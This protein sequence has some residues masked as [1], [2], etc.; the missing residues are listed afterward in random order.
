M[1]REDIIVKSNDEVF[2][3]IIDTFDRTLAFLEDNPEFNSLDIF[4]L[5]KEDAG[6]SEF[7][8]GG[9]EEL[10]EVVDLCY[11]TPQKLNDLTKAQ[12]YAIGIFVTVNEIEFRDE[13]PV[14]AAM[15]NYSDTIELAKEKFIEHREVLTA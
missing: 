14:M 5:I 10:M 7:E 6:L 8:E 2:D 15:M 1:D 13:D 12:G 4:N 3:A 9:Y 11:D